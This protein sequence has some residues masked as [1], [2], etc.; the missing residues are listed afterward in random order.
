MLPLA[1]C[2]CIGDNLRIYSYPAKRG[3]LMDKKFFMNKEIPIKYVLTQDTKGLFSNINRGI[4]LNDN[5]FDKVSNRYF[6]DVAQAIAAI[7]DPDKV[8]E[9]YTE[10][11]IDLE[12]Q[13]KVKPLLQVT[14]TCCI[15]LDRF[16]LSNLE[17]SEEFQKKFF[18]FS[19]CRTTNNIRVPRQGKLTFT[20]QLRDLKL[21]IPDIEQRETILIDDGL[22][23]GGSAREFVSLASE[24]GI[25]LK[26]NKIIGFIGN[27]TYLDKSGLPPVE[28]IKNIDN[29]YDWIDIRD[30][31]PLGGKKFEASKTNMVTSTVPYIYPW[32][33][34][35][36]ASLDFTPRFYDASIQ[37][38][39]SFQDV[40]EQYEKSSSA[41]LTFRRLVKTGYPLPTNLLKTIP[42]SINDRVGDYLTRC[43]NIIQQEQQ[44]E[45]AVFDMDGTLYQLDGINNGFSGSTL[46]SAVLQKAKKFIKMK[47]QCS[48]KDA[49]ALLQTALT[50][51]IGI[52]QYLAIRY[53]ISR[54]EYFEFTWNINP[55]GIVKDYENAA[56]TVKLLK[57]KYPNKKMVILT[58][59]PKVWAEKVLSFI[60]VSDE[61]EALYTG[62][63]YGSKKEIFAM[64][65]ERY[66]PNNITSI[67]D[68]EETDIKPA[69]LLGLKTVLV[70]KPDDIRCLLIEDGGIICQ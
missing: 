43:V 44:R 18:R 58:Q 21:A 68:Q 8:V 32:S 39:K 69:Q 19:L 16:L 34:G 59:A 64:L 46:E 13:Q 49:E 50:D 66:I 9:Q 67:G 20:E 23:T 45:V 15:C 56:D 24:N 31:S 10:E 14:N 6:S 47:E 35:A 2:D 63:Q 3:F 65:A 11:E 29:L 7:L 37:I 27:N 38:I 22:F 25:R 52:S 41:P 70:N 12:L 48:D 5:D 17:E 40:V 57:S 62:E 51:P 42:V 60:G 30:F 55:N 28:I 26:I 33:D 53:N 61:F 36:S 1:E 4:D 54:S